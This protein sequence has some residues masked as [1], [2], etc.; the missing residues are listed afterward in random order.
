MYR[1]VHFFNGFH[2]G[3]VH[4]SREFVRWIIKNVPAEEY[5]YSHN[6]SHK[7]IMDVEGLKFNDFVP[8]ARKSQW[9]IDSD[10]LSVNTS[11]R[12][13][14]EIHDKYECSIQCLYHMFRQCL[15][16][17][18]VDLAS[19][20]ESFIPRIDYDRY[21]IGNARMYMESIKRFKKVFICNGK[22]LSGQAHN[23][24]FDPTIRYLASKYKDTYFLLTNGNNE[25][26]MPNV[27]YT[28]DIIKTMDNDLNE[29]A[30]VAKHCPI[31]VGRA[32][33]PHAF[34]WNTDNLGKRVIAFAED[35]RVATFGLN[36]LYP[37][38]FVH[39][40]GRA[41]V[42]GLISREIDGLCQS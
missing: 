27:V 17:I 34:C 29:N 41:D 35:E 15:G 11:F 16:E 40:P 37:D 32:S 19:N 6:Y 39:Y 23:F 18:G 25:I 10:I 42:A 26:A 8:M 7:L 22:V 13:V 33:G 9:I 30:Y 1:R 14:P 38:G 28:K 5:L 20:I 31:I 2:N 21:E 24:S 4:V 3:D 36:E 12:T